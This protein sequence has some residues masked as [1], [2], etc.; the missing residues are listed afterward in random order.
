M[1][2]ISALMCK[3]H[4]C[5]SLYLTSTVKIHNVLSYFIFETFLDLSAVR[6]TFCHFCSH[7]SDPSPCLPVH[8]CSKCPSFCNSDRLWQR[9]VIFSLSHSPHCVCSS[10]GA[11]SAVTKKGLQQ[12]LCLHNTRLQIRTCCMS[13]SAQVE[14]IYCT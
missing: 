7:F 3:V 13:H 10:A 11:E 1:E 2:A 14:L 6:S 9:Q 12:I 5:F 4:I 8:L